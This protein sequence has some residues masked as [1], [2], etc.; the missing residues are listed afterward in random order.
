VL[1]KGRNGISGVTYIADFTYIDNDMPVVADA[2]GYK[3]NAVYVLK[4]R[5]MYL[6]HG[7][8]IEEL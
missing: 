4:K 6:L 2:K 5:M 3:K 7:I 8:E 1:I